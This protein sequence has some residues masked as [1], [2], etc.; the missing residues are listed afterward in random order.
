LNQV[1]PSALFV[2]I[3]RPRI[4]I[5]RSLLNARKQYL[6][7][8]ESWFGTRTLTEEAASKMS[9]VSQVLQQVDNM[10]TVIS[11]DLAEFVSLDRHITLP[12]EDLC[13][14]PTLAMAKISEF[15]EKH[16]LDLSIRDE[17]PEKF[18]YSC[19][20][21]LPDELEAELLASWGMYEAGRP[22]AFPS[23]AD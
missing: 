5:A 12:Y 9:A 3:S 21:G 15:A 20:S 6:G 23:A 17:L 16:G 10:E 1:F 8:Y 4:E 18:D 11:R 13:R 2:R 7:S 19:G 22:Q 14:N